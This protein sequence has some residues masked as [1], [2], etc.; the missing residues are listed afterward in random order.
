MQHPAPVPHPRHPLASKARVLLSSVFG[1]YGQDDEYGSRKINPMELYQNQVTRSQ[2]SFS[3]RMFH[4]SF[5]L[6][7]I[8]A[9]INAPCTLLDFPT[10]ERFREELLVQSYDVIGISGII[11]NVGKVQEMCALIRRHQPGATIVIGGH[12]ANKEGLDRM[13]DADHI[14][15]GE[16]IRWMQR[17]LGQDDQSPVKHPATLSSFGSRVM[18]MAIGDTP[19]RTAAILI[20]SVGCPLGC[21]FCSTSAQ[22]GGKGK[23]V[24]FYETG[25]ELFAVMV[26][27]ESELKVR[28]F[29]VLDENFLLH[30]KRSLRL[31]ELMEAHGKSWTLSVFSSARVLKSYTME[32]LAG[33]GISFVWMGLEGEESAYDKL[34]GVDTLALVQ[35][36][37]DNGI[38]VLG[39]TI[40]GLEE[41]RP[42]EMAAIIEYAVRHD[43]VFH[44]FMLYTPIP[45]TPLHARH[46]QE[47]TLLPEKEFPFAD[48]H[49]QYRFNYRHPHFSNGE[50][51]G[52]LLEAFSRD[53]AANGPSLLRLIRVL[54][55]GWQTHRVHTRRI[56]DRFAWEAA[57][58]RTTYAGVVWAMRKYYHDTPH[59]RETADRLLADIYTAFGWKTRLAAPL[60]G[61]YIYSRLQ[62]EDVRLAAGF[63]YEPDSFCEKNS[64]A[65]ALEKAV[66]A[67]SMIGG[68]ELFPVGEPVYH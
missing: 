23:F 30:K 58:L 46:Q 34:K 27:I 20:P 4:R 50:E 63:S 64:A 26:G 1:P 53:F 54:L 2:G 9:N 45:G 52:W 25:D 51:E 44:Q 10:L 55:N 41:H 60:I 31:L 35:L 62:Q 47:G 11:A 24:N 6:M 56:R 43:T 14:V 28:S 36:L 12:I 37:Q 33:L 61:R 40:L 7:M 59:Q 39:S 18:G 49:G 67:E 21:N 42:A 22:F 48:A 15:R 57:P 66:A 16:G 19:E 8:Q 5:G 68:G 38:R 3:L 17:Y 29:F 32:Q 13:I 65:I